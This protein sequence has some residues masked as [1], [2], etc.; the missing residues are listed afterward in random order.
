MWTMTI[1]LVTV[2]VYVII[3]FCSSNI[4]VQFYIVEVYYTLKPAVVVIRMQQ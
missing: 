3:I 2:V 4:C 1:I